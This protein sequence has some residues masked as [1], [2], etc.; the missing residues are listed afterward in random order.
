VSAVEIDWGSAQVRSG[1][2]NVKFAAEPSSAWRKRFGLLARRLERPG[3]SWGEITVKKTRIRVSEISEGAESDVHHFLESVVLETNA[4]EQQD[5]VTTDDEQ[6]GL[7]AVD[8]RMTDA[9]QRFQGNDG[10]RSTASSGPA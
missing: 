7:D 10:D 4:A 9:F 1:E 6:D 5:P 2:L 8:R 3:E